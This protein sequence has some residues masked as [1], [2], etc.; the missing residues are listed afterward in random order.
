MADSQSKVLAIGAADE[1]EPGESE[2]AGGATRPIEK[3]LR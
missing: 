1:A 2:P 3:K